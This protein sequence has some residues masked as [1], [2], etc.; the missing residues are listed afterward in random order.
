MFSYWLVLF[1]LRAFICVGL[2]SLS[3]F[4][5]VITFLHL[6]MLILLLITCSSVENTSLNRMHRLHDYYNRYGYNKSCPFLNDAS[7]E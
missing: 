6:R 1:E 3:R 5:R 4:H 7:Y 2:G